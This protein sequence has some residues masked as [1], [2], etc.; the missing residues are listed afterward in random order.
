MSTI[1]K[2]ATT[3]VA[4]TARSHPAPRRATSGSGAP[5]TVQ[6]ERPRGSVR[7]IV[8]RL[9]ALT[10]LMLAGAGTLL[11]AEQ[12]T[13]QDGSYRVKSG[14]LLLI[15]VWREPELQREVVVRPDGGVS[16]PLS[17][18]LV[19]TG[20]TV[21]ELRTEI[22]ARLERFIS[23]PAV[24][25][26]VQEVRGNTFFVLG[27]VAKPGQYIIRNDLDVMQALS[28]AGGTTT[29]A[30][31]NDIKILRRDGGKQ[32][33]IPFRYGDVEDGENL[34]QNILLRSGDVVVVP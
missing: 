28:M 30:K 23:E 24:S 4:N 6:G 10:L 5:A 8:S 27:K 9:A 12:A 31:L 18:D 33:A 15:S 11:P 25:V 3:Q 17:G 2:P 22:G 16:L 26:S 1:T 29:F 32:N 7:S 34:A 19:A 20:R 13:A 21:E 14:D